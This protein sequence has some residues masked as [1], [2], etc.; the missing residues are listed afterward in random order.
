MKITEQ[1]LS[2]LNDKYNKVN[3]LKLYVGG[4]EGQKHVLLHNLVGA[5]ESLQELQKT[6]EEEYGK[7]NIDLATGEYETIKED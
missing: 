2:D 1:Q 3:Q 6:L 5:Q 7:I 4:L